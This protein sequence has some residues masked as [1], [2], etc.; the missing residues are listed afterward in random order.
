MKAEFVSLGIVLLFVSL[1]WGSL[2][3][4]ASYYFSSLSLSNNVALLVKTCEYDGNSLYFGVGT[5]CWS[6]QTDGGTSFVLVKG[7]TLYFHSSGIQQH[8]TMNLV[9]PNDTRGYSALDVPESFKQEPVLVHLTFGMT[10]YYVAP[11][12]QLAY[13]AVT[14][15]TSFFKFPYRSIWHNKDEMNWWVSGIPFRS[16]KAIVVER[17]RRE[18][19]FG[20]DFYRRLMAVPQHPDIASALHGT[21]TTNVLIAVVGDLT[22][23]IPQQVQQI[24][25]RVVGTVP[26]RHIHGIRWEYS[27][28]GRNIARY[29][30]DR[31]GRLT[32]FSSERAAVGDDGKTVLADPWV[33]EYNTEGVLLRSFDSGPNPLLVI[34]DRTFYFSGENSRIRSFLDDALEATRDLL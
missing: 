30:Y 32:W 13:S 11:S 17:A 1:S 24:Q 29:C 34:T 4:N 14:H 22:N 33:F 16:R 3:E 19:S 10:E 28:N 15:R 20:E 23:G 27:E 2:D 7:E 18:K 12:L 8:S 26:D 31:V 21:G 25:I 5:N 9:T 6:R